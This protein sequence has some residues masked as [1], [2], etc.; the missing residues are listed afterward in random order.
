EQIV[1]LIQK[2]TSGIVS[3]DPVIVSSAAILAGGPVTIIEAQGPNTVILVLAAYYTL[4]IGTV[5]TATDS[6]ST[7]LYIGG[8]AVDQGDNSVETGGGGTII[9]G[10]GLT[11][12]LANATGL[13]NQPVVWANNG[14]GSWINGTAPL[15]V[16][17]VY[18]VFNVG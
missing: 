13:V 6:L 7:G 10:S 8:V 11:A 16:A 5:Y 4:G 9:S 15:T 12:P 1:A 14:P 2:G 17:V 18:A 3:A